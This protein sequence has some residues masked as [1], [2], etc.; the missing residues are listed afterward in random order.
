M[1]TGKD[2]STKDIVTITIGENG[3][4]VKKDKFA[5]RFDELDKCLLNFLLDYTFI[6]ESRRF[7]NV[8]Y[9]VK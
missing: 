5:S 2:I 1:H 3:N 8:Q 6:M 7:S 4:I 9:R